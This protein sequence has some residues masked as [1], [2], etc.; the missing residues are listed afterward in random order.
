[1]FL[2]DWIILLYMGEKTKGL[3]SIKIGTSGW[4]YPHWREAFYPRGLSSS[5][6][7]GFYAQHFETVE[8]N[9]TFY[10][11]PKN[12]TLERWYK[13]TPPNFTF[14]VKANRYI[15]H[16]KRL[17]EVKEAME[18]LY[19][20]LAPLKGKLGV[21]LFQLP[22][23]LS[24]SYERMEEFLRLL[25][26]SIPT[27]V[28][29]RHKSFI[30]QEFFDLLRNHQVAF[31]ISDT[32]GHYPSLAYEITA[33]FTYIRLHGSRL[34]YA[35]N[36]TLEELSEWAN[37]IKSWGVNAFVYFDNDACGYAVSNALQ[38]KKIIEAQG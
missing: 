13:R 20:D 19:R 9:A 12:S 38:L 33:D 25:D 5:Q 10:G 26:P 16:I 1:M 7:L 4:N 15:T 34:L 27:T 29:V 36:Y 31:C 24:F 6:W 28:E 8:I 2:G 23:S 37:R 18:R 35:S 11:R 3:T 30:T 14:S 32:A 21:L 22:P 17:K